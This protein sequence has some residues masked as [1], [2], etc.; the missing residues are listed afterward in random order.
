MSPPAKKNPN[1]LRIP[2]MCCKYFYF[3]I[4][5][6]IF[7]FL[8]KSNLNKHFNFVFSFTLFSVLSIVCVCLAVYYRWYEF[9]EVV[10]D[11]RRRRRCRLF[12]VFYAFLQFIDAQPTA[13]LT[14]FVTLTYTN[15]Q[16]YS[17]S[18]VWCYWSR[19]VPE[20]VPFCTL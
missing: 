5:Q 9:S 16:L 20:R 8:F 13:A 4:V 2:C 15:N 17:V 14:I 7:Y 10:D 18:H 1:K 3:N 19:C 6:L 11:R 12:W